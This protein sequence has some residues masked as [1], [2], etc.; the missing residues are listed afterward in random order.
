MR[1][2]NFAHVFIYYG[3]SLAQYRG[4]FRYILNL[5]QVDDSTPFGHLIPLPQLLLN[6]LQIFINDIFQNKSMGFF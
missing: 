6:S 3:Q 2:L 1:G 4:Q 5:T